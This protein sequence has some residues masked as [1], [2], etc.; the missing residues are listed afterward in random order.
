MLETDPKLVNDHDRQ[1]EAALLKQG[2]GYAER[3]AISKRDFNALRGTTR[4]T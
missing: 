3:N 1:V 2:E 4:R